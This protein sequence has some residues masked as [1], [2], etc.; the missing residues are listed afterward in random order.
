M[1]LWAGYVVR[2]TRR[3]LLGVLPGGI[4]LSFVLSYTE[5]SPYILLPLIVGP[6]SD[7][8]DEPGRP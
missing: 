3:P 5:K 2:R 1:S 7:G 4:V 8:D 6:W